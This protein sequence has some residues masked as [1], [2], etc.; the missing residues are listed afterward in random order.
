VGLGGRL[1]STN[2]VEPAL[3]VITSLEREHEDLLGPGLARIAA[4]KAGILRPGVVLLS[5]CRG[6]A[7]ALLAG[8]AA[9]RGAPLLALGRDFILRILERPREG[10]AVE[11]TLAGGE[12][13][14]ARTGLKAAAHLASLA[15]AAQASALLGFPPSGPLLAA[16]SRAALPG[17]FELLLG[18]PDWLVDGAH[19][20]RSLLRLSR[21]LELWFPGRPYRLL[22]GVAR[23]KRW[24]TAFRSLAG[25]AADARAVTLPGGRGVPAAEL[26]GA[27]PGKVLACPDLDEAYSRLIRGAVPGD[28]A[29]ATGSFRVAGRVRALVLGAGE[30]TRRKGEKARRPPQW[31]SSRTCWSLSRSSSAAGWRGRPSA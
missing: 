30:D 3:T 20:A 11:L 10:F 17:R 29:L 16:A 7:A 12:R 5:A 19:T 26:A 2:A 25:R 1:D 21:D 31:R 15:L 24:R 18:R 23:D 14:A 9:R 8:E 4:E 6:R 22:F 27:L 28:L 13:L